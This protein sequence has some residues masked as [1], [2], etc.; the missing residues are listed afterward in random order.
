MPREAIFS[1]KLPPSDAPFS[2]AVR[3]GELIF[4]SGQVGT[5]PTT[6]KLVHGGVA[7]QTEQALHNLATVL[8]AAGRTL[9]DVVR[10]G[11][12]LT[13]MANFPAMNQVYAHHFA[14][15]FP[16]RTTIGVAALPMGALVEID[17]VAR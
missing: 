3:A 13:D 8:E 11:V 1:D 2:P 6:G 4:L 17:L 5:D 12:Y 15:P 14:Q 7:E 10:V 9:D 16:A